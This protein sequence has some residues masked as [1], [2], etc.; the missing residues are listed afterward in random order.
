MASR[1]MDEGGESPGAQRSEMLAALSICKYVYV[2]TAYKI[3]TC[4]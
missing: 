2:G 1:P 4:M 3:L